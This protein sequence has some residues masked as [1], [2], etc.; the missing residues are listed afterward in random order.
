MLGRLVRDDYLPG[1][2][3]AVLALL[4]DWVRW[5]A[6]RAGLPTGLAAPVLEAARAEAAI[7]VT[8]DHGPGDEDGDGTPFRRKEL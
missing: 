7:P 3:N 4:P 6:D 8:D 5:C 2:G 1:E